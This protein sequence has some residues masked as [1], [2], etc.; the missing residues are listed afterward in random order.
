LERFEQTLIAK[1]LACRVLHSDEAGSNIG[2]KPHWPH[3]ISSPQWTLYYARDKRGREAL[4]AVIALPRFTGSLAHDHWRP[5]F[6]PTCRNAH[7][8]RELAFAHEQGHQAWAS[9]MIG[10]LQAM[11]HAVNSRPGSLPEP[12][13]TDFI[14]LYRALLKEAGQECPPPGPSRTPGKR[15]KPRNLLERLIDQETKTLRFLADPDAPFTN[16]Q[17]GRA[18]F[19]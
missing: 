19:G 14:A 11:T 8:L 18:T 12:R 10:L 2:G 4:R 3:C 16:N 9:R 17:G 6:Q 1:L 15:S 5:Y 13:A 7:H